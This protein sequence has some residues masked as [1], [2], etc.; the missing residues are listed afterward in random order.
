[1]KLS[2]VEAGHASDARKEPER[3]IVV[4]WFPSRNNPRKELFFIDI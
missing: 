2:P 1:M 3:F 4:I